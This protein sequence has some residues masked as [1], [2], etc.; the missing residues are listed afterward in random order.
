M[1]TFTKMH[2]EC[3]MSKQLL[4]KAALPIFIGLF[5]IVLNSFQNS[6]SLERMIWAVCAVIACVFLFLFVV[7]LW[8]KFSFRKGK[9]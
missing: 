3:D 1:V 9:Q 8:K 6:L 7:E 4:R 2:G 5:V